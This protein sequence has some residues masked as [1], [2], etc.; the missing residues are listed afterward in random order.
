MSDTHLA[1]KTHHVLETTR[2]A[3]SGDG[4]HAEKGHAH[5]ILSDVEVEHQLEE[6]GYKQEMKR[7]L[8]MVAVLGLSF[9]IMAVPFGTQCDTGAR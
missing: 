9:A 4:H 1:E 2:S 7:S 6:M 5:H 8:G 3:R